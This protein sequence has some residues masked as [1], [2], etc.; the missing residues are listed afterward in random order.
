M[1]GG[2]ATPAAVWAERDAALAAV[3]GAPLLARVKAARLL[4][5]GAGGIGCELLKDLVLTGF[6]RID[7]LD[8]DTIDVSNLNRQ[9]LFRP[10]HVGKSKAEVARES[11][12]AMAPPSAAAT[13]VAHHANVKEERFGVA[14]VEQFD[15]VLSAL[16]NVAARRHVNRVCL[17][18]GVS[19]IE[20]GTAG[21]EGQAFV[22]RKGVT[23][24]FECRPKTVPKTFA[25]CTIRSTPDQPVHCCVWAKELHKL[26]VGDAKQSHLYEETTSAG[27]GVGAASGGGRGAS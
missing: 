22:I 1:E 10:H 3:L 2:V 24:C 25:V 12:L 14:F 15:L 21:Y 5:I 17:A 23:E 18:A 19:L 27:A 13:L 11:V 20:A 9:F 8:L 7:A 4:V 6:E 16:D 26:L